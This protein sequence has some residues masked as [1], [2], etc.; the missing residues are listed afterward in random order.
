MS[1]YKLSGCVPPNIMSLLEQVCLEHCKNIS[2][3]AVRR[4]KGKLARD[5]GEFYD[6]DDIS[7][8]EENRACWN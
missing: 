5:D 7:D 2:E 6:E 4:L 3:M 8:W 1:V